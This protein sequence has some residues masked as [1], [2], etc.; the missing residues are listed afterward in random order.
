MRSRSDLL[1][2][3]VQVQMAKRGREEH[4][5]LPQVHHPAQNEEHNQ[6]TALKNGRDFG[7]AEG[8]I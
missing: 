4:E 5:L 8:N 1:E 6:Q 2:S 7:A 3:E